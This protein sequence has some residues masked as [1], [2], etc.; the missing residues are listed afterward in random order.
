MPPQ[1]APGRAAGL[2]RAPAR[3]V[4]QAHGAAGREPGAGSRWDLRLWPHGGR[5]GA[6]RADDERLR[7][8]RGGGLPAEVGPLACDAAFAR[9]RSAAAAAASRTCTRTNRRALLLAA[10]ALLCVQA[11]GGAVR[12]A[13]RAAAG[14]LPQLRRRQHAGPGAPAGVSS[15]LQP[16]RRAAC[17]RLRP[18]QQQHGAGEPD[19]SAA[20]APAGASGEPD[21]VRRRATCAAPEPGLGWAALR[22]ALWHEDRCEIRRAA[23]TRDH[24]PPAHAGSGPWCTA[25]CSRRGS[26]RTQHAG[27]CCSCWTCWGLLAAQAQ[28][29]AAAAGA[30]AARRPASSCWG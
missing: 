10:P 5:A 7:Q 15:G 16:L 9:A 30:G 1:G 8:L 12:A 25:S 21:Q 6:E 14:R 29:E 3:G 24:P 27:C 17:A 18:G 4:P 22:C 28:G 26:C 13:V 23:A 2:P 20:A 19:G 11:A